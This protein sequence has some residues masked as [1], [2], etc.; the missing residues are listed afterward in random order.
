MIS[1]ILVNYNSKKYL[2]NCIPALLMH[3]SGDKEVVIVD[4]CSGED[5]SEI[6]QLDDRVKVIYYDQN[7]GFGSGINRGAKEAQGDWLLFV[8]PDAQ[9]LGDPQPLLESAQADIGLIGFSLVKED[10]SVQAYQ[11]G[12]KPTPWTMITGSLKRQWPQEVPETVE[13]DWIGGG[14]MAVRRS[15]FEQLGGFDDRY[16]MYFEDIDLC[17]RVRDLGYRL[18]WT[19]QIQVRH[20]EGGSEPVKWKVKKRYYASARQFVAKWY[21]PIWGA[22]LWLPHW[23]TV[24]ILGILEKR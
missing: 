1:C 17:L 22:V 23:L 16:F 18:L 12:A 24:R 9:L 10:S 4:N 14:A 20:V 11:F 7:N 15:I 3:I 13:P 5:L 8:N 6:E 19:Q 21:A 2:E